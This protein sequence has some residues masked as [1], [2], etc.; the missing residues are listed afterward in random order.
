MAVLLTRR[1]HA[2]ESRLFGLFLFIN[3]S[4][5]QSQANVWVGQSL[6]WA[7]RNLPFVEVGSRC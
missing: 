2:Q 7:S 3:S 1:N 5:N 6:N 4:A